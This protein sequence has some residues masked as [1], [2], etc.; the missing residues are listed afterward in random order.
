M[1]A[2]VRVESED[3]VTGEI[4]HTASAYLTYVALNKEGKPTP[5]P[6]LMPETEEE[7]RRNREALAR[8][9]LRLCGRMGTKEKG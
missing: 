4:R 5:V 6:L 2:G 7:I 9:N 8:R 1:E 3:L